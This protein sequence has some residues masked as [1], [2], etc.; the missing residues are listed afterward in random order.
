MPEL[1]ATMCTDLDEVDRA[2]W[3]RL[4]RPSF[5]M[6]Y[7]WMAARADTVGGPLRLVLVHNEEGA[8]VLGAPCFVTDASSHPRYDPVGVLTEWRI[9][10]PQVA[11]G[12]RPALV[13]AAPTLAGG[14]AAAPWLRERERGD[15][16]DVAIA[17][18]EEFA[19]RMAVR[20]VAWLYLDEGADDQL[21]Q[22]L[23][24]RSY[25]QSVVE[26][27]CH[28]PVVWASFDEYLEHLKASG[29]RSVV[30][31]RER[32]TR[33]GG[34][35]ELGGHDL[36][37]SDLAGLEAQWREKYGRDA[38]HEEIVG[39]YELLRRHGL[40]PRLRVFV[41][42][43]GDSAV[44]FAAFFEEDEVWYARF[45]G[46]DYAAGDM[47][48]YFN[49]VF[50]SPIEAAIDRGIRSIRY[51]F[52]SYEAKRRRG[53]LLQNVRVYVRVPAAAESCTRDHLAE[54]DSRRRAEFAE[55]AAAHAK[56][57]A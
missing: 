44:G 16:L 21:E 35:I 53:C 19:E 11:A 45:F 48:L 55:I 34:R 39:Q 50:Y 32:L 42:R 10:D 52:E 56:A 51:S 26:A 49:L 54:L 25:L 27:E 13:V 7:D 23:S 30:R 24:A 2:A 15:A 28:L 1:R 12:L 8:L 4:E 3:E 5:Y 17:A 31:E 46:F 6:S 57:T 41:A 20:V 47:A 9:E 33:A 14:V 37:G 43:R 40:A 38:P 22:R 18:L 36:L 29:R